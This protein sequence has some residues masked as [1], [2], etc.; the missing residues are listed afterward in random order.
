[1][2]MFGRE[3]A[4]DDLVTKLVPLPE[5]ADLEQAKQ[6]VLDDIFNT[7]PLGNWQQ[8]EHPAE[9]HDKTG[10]R[11]ARSVSRLCQYRLRW[12]ATR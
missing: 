8:P 4:H 1:M 5:G 2:D 10:N 7:S 9:Q 12:S 11:F 3:S 6:N